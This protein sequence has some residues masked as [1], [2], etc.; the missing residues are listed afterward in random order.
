MG[1]FG[2]DDDDNDSG[3]SSSFGGGISDFFGGIADSIGSALGAADKGIRDVAGYVGGAADSIGLSG[4]VKSFDSAARSGLDYL[5]L[6]TTTTYDSGFSTGGGDKL[7]QNNA[8]TAPQ[9]AQPAPASTIPDAEDALTNLYS[10]Y[11]SRTSYND[12]GGLSGGHRD[13]LS[14]FSGKRRVI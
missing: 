5:G 3:R 7:F 4:A 10:K 14:L 6:D 12:I 1:W 8:N 9:I 2:G 11:R 13:L